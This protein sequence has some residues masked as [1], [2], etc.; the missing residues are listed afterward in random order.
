MT[1][2][3][4]NGK[5]LLASILYLPFFFIACCILPSSADK[6]SYY[7]PPDNMVFDCSPPDSS[8]DV[9]FLDSKRYEIDFSSVSRV[10]AIDPSNQE[11]PRI[12]ACLML[13][14]VNW[15]FT[16]SDGPKFLRLHFKPVTYSGLDVSK[17][18]FSISVGSFKLITTSE[19]S[20]SKY[21]PITD[22][23]IREFC[24]NTDGQILKVTFTPSSQVSGAYAFVNKIEIV[25]MPSKLYMQ[26]DASFSLA[27]QP[28]SY[29]MGNSTALEMMHRVNIG[30]DVISGP[31]DIG[32]FRRWT[33]DDDYFMSDDGNT[34]IVE[35]EVEVKS[36]LLKPA[37]YVAPL[38]VYTSARTILQTTESKYR[39]RWAFPVDYGF[40]YLVR[41]HFCEISRIIKRDGQ[42]VFRVYIN[43][44]TV[45]D[46]AD[47]FNWT[48]G[49][50]I[51]IY[52]DYIVNFSNYGEGV[53]YLSIA[54]GSTNG[55]FAK[56]GSPIL[57]GLEIFKL[58][59]FSNN[60]A[61]PHPFGVKVAPHSYFSIRDDAER[62]VMVIVVMVFA[63]LLLA[64][65]AIGLLGFGYLFYSQ[66]NRQQKSSKQDQSLGYCRIFTIAEIKSATNNFA[67]A[68]L[69]GTG[70]FGTVYKGSIDGGIT[71]IA[72]KRANRSSHQGLK[73]FQTE[74]SLLSKLRHSH[75]VSL[76]GYCTEEKEMILVYEPAVTP[77]GEI[78]EDE[79]EKVSL[80]EWALHCCQMGNLDQIIDPYLKGKIA[81]DCFKTFAAIARKCLVDRGS[82]RPTMGDVLWNL[83]LAMQQHEGV[84][85]QEVSRV[86]KEANGTMNGDLRIMIDN[87]RS[88]GFD[89]SDPNPGV[90]F[91][92]IMVP[93]GR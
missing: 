34:S 51:P 29:S 71:S 49:V 24:V 12:S 20:Y 80:A 3:T 17:A 78:G 19:S 23:A 40:Y 83:E 59:D 92:D 10:Y 56:Y 5:S 66:S 65:Y 42:R 16:V 67:D 72:V 77:M 93:T 79:H 25:S 57:N 90:E 36:S 8:H 52:K 46:H 81:P 70:G 15:S 32:M 2:E 88:S 21:F 85:G 61:G 76:I 47:V 27:G 1:T 31:E 28:S 91:S 58:S 73:E 63:A 89:I 18:L 13:K 7:I 54:L 39:A 62:H 6:Q 48:H 33:R 35:S 82:E 55:S 22:Y 45:E 43:N 68:L 26:E 37:A 41:L 4:R 84:G 86:Q 50:G 30:G 38:Q 60:L 14:Q 44:Q 87:H 74:I 75:L 64:C 9:G 53:K 11:K 69:I